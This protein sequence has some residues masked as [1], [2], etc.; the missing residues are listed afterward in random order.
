MIK[1]FV[2]D[3]DGVLT[4]GGMYYTESGDEF[5][6]FNTLD[7]M[8]FELLR[9]A[10]VKTGLITSETS[11][12]VER[13]ALKIKANYLYQG[14]FGV[15]KLNAVHEICAIENISL[16]NVAYIGDDLNCIELLKAVGYKACPSSANYLVKEIPGI[17][18][19]N[20]AGGE[21]VVREWV[22]LL[23]I[24]NKF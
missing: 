10:S 24:E 2:S 11:K 7:G 13:R 15:G 9:K 23:L 1:L 16:S 6:M 3:V 14:C 20:K 18:I 19:L 5:K 12:I 4:D 22:D 8:G 17:R 21:G